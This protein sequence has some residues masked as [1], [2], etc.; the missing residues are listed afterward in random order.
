MSRLARSVRLTILLER[1][2]KVYKVLFLRPKLVGRTVK[3]RRQLL[4]IAR[5]LHMQGKQ[6]IIRH[7]QSPRENFF[8][9]AF[10]CE[11]NGILMC[12]MWRG[13]Q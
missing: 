5:A 12:C 13:K 7:G 1:A 3:T 10:G 6:F 8:P 11:Q 9:L 2:E 4:G